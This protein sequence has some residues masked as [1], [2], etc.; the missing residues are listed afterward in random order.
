MEIII[1]NNN[2]LIKIKEEI[3]CHVYLIVNNVK[4]AILAVNVYQVLI[5]KMEINVLQFV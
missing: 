5:Y 3:A 1:I 4:I 2:Q